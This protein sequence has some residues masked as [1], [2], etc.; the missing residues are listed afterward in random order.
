[1][2]ALLRPG[3]EVGLEEGRYTSLAVSLRIIPMPCILFSSLF[4]SM[5]RIWACGGILVCD[6]SLGVPY[7]HF[8]GRW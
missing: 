1:M 4:I 7:I 2:E 5:T 8:S 6:I 3:V